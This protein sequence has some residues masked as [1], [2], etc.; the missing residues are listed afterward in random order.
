MRCPASTYIYP[1]VRDRNPNK[2]GSLGVTQLYPGSQRCKENESAPATRAVSGSSLLRLLFL[3]PRLLHLSSARQ[4]AAG[5]MNSFRPDHDH[6]VNDLYSPAA[7]AV[8]SQVS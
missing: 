1:E 7:L 6:P 8:E 3:S 5:P 2:R 4:A